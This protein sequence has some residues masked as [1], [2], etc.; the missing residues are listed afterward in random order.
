MLRMLINLFVLL[1]C[2]GLA[3]AAVW[4]F[5]GKKPFTEFIDDLKASPRKQIA[6]G[7]SWSAPLWLILIVWLIIKSARA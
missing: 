2:M 6:L 1:C 4:F 3:V 7:F 5:S